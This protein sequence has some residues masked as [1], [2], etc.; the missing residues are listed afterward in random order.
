MFNRRR[1]PVLGAAVLVGASR[2]A[3]RHEV[4][5]QA[6]AESQR[7]MDIQREVEV[8]RLRE[9]EMEQRTQRAVDEAMKKAA[10]ENPAPQQ[11]PAVMMVQPPPQQFYNNQQPI[12][13]QSP[14]QSYTVGTNMMPGLQPEQIMRA[15]SPQPPAYSS[16][17]LSQDRP[18]SAQG[19]G[20]AS[21]ALESSV[22]YCSQCGFSCQIG[23]KFCSRCGSK[24]VP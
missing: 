5:R 17:S 24:Q 3:A 15:P 14:G 16:E 12:P 21:P 6:V 13:I 8:R 19:I 23:D 20:S 10:L 9:V 11:S 7:E 18:K 2:A 4:Q 1:R 22:R